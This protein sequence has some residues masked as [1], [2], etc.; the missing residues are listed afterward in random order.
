MRT[1]QYGF[2]HEAVRACGDLAWFPL[3]SASGE[4]RWTPNP[5]KSRTR[6]SRYLSR[7]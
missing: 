5:R 1:R 6:Y 2:E 3:L 4:L 7:N